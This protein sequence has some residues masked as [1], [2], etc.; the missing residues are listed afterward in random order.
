MLESA[1]AVGDALEIR[2]AREGW[3]KVGD[4]LR[5]YDL[6]VERERRQ[7]GEMVNRTEIERHVSA[8]VQFFKIAAR[9]TSAAL[10]PDLAG[11]TTPA[12]VCDLLDKGLLDQIINACVGFASQPC[13]AQVPEWFL[14]AALRPMDDALN[15]AT[16]TAKARR[17]AF[18][19][20]FEAMCERSTRLATLGENPFGQPPQGTA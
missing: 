14:A 12:E 18:R 5:R 9:R 15:D 20:V 6:L 3:L 8:F 17:K 16:G 1:L 13:K 10:A 11:L 4:S 7:S 19:E 2:N